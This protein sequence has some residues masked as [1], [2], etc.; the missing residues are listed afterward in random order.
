MGA[1]EEI[2]FSM[3]Y[4]GETV[5]LA[6]A[7]ATLEVLRREPVLEHI[8]ARGAELREGIQRLAGGVSFGVDL[9]GNPPRSAIGF[10]DREGLPSP[11][12][13]GLFL[14]ECHKAGCSL[15]GLS[16]RPTA[17]ARA[18]SHRRSRWSRCALGR[19]DDA[20][21]GGEV[22]ARLR[23]TPARRGVPLARLISTCSR[24]HT[25]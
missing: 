2:F 9:A 16:S 13:R 3:T 12:L 18:T 14:Q 24:F 17:T 1:F 8:W 20:Y 6:A 15:A 10:S 21:R 23:G 7:M 11:L 4:S 19:M 5:S 25:A 22:E